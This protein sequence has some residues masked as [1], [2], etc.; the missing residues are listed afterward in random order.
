MICGRQ[1]LIKYIFKLLFVMMIHLYKP[2]FVK[3]IIFLISDGWQPPHFGHYK[4]NFDAAIYT[5]LGCSGVG[6]IIRNERGEVMATLSTKESFAQDSEEAETLACRNALEFAIDVGISDLIIEG[7]NVSVMRVVASN[8]MDGSRLGNILEDIHC[9]VSA[10]R[11]CF[12]SCVKR[13][14]N[15][16]AHSL[17]RFARNVSDELV[18][19][20]DSPQPAREALY[21][22]SLIFS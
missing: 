6:A 11:W 22:D 5:D 7:D 16:V 4:L 1:Q 3:F 21:T 13:S 20:K 14:A 2:H 10:L 17:A 8:C 18:W 9:L 12:V 15:T 19:I